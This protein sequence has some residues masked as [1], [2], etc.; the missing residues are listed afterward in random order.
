[1]VGVFNAQYKAAPGTTQEETAGEEAGKPEESK[2][3]AEEATAKEAN[4]AAE[5][6][7]M[8]AISGVVSPADVEGLAGER[9]AV[10]A[11]HLGQCRALNRHEQ[12]GLALP[13]L[14][15]EV[16]T[17]VPIENGVAPIG[18]ADML[19]SAGALLFK[20]WV[21]PPIRTKPCTRC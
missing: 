12:W 20:G 6:A 13:P 9:F 8:Q 21:N 11:H 16:F 5:A 4:A 17:I 3:A 19:N 1:M 14:N 7:E 18:L 2:A 15:G 10:Y